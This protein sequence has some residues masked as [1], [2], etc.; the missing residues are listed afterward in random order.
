MLVDYPPERKAELLNVADLENV[1][2]LDRQAEHG[3]EQPR[4]PPKELHVTPLPPDALIIVPVRNLVLFPGMVM[5]VS[6]GRPK[7]VAAAQQ[8]VREQSQIGIL[9]QR[10]SDVTDPTGLDMH[11]MGTVSNVIRYI[12]GPE[13]TN[14]LVCQGEQRFQVLEF[15]DGWPFLVARVL[16]I[17]EIV[18]KTP[19]IEAR[20]HHLRG[21]ALEALELMPQAPRELAGAIQ[22]IESPGAL[23]DL[24][25]AYMDVKPDEKQEVLETIDLQLES[26]RSRGCSHNVSKCFAYLQ[27][28][29]SKQRL[30]ST[31][32]SA[33]YC[34][35]NKWRRFKSSLAKERRAKL[36]KWLNSTKP[37]LVP[38]C[39]RKWKKQRARSSVDCNA[40]LKA[41]RNM[42]WS[43]HISTG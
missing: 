9:K 33:R 42:E 3:A 10:D 17:P 19:E 2:G 35:A 34:C 13:G 28:L 11:R 25:M 16:R 24:V 30:R 27:R 36:P 15:L 8:A 12:T 29:E 23:A 43:A 7:S 37:F 4:T 22:A 40:C 26:K 18:S 14:H 1:R 6:V 32:G 38:A 39:Q 41:R 20:F 31:N 21:Q 5:P